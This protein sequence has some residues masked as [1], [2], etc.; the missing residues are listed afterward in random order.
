PAHRGG[1]ITYGYQ[2][3]RSE[4]AGEFLALSRLTDLGFKDLFRWGLMQSETWE[5]IG[6]VRVLERCVAADPLDRRSRLALS[7]IMRGLG[8]LNRAEEALAGLDLAGPEVIAA[9]VRI[10]LDRRDRSR[11]ERL[12]AS[13]L[14]GDPL[15]ARLRG[16]MALSRGDAR[17]ALRYYRVAYE[18]HPDVHEVLT[19]L[20]TALKILGDAE[21]LAPLRD[22][23]GKRNRL[24]LLIL[25]ASSGPGRDDP[26]LPPRL[27]DA[28]AALPRDAE[29]R[30]W[31]KLAIARN[32]LD[33]RAQRALFQLGT[34][35]RDGPPPDAPGRDR[36]KP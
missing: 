3:G 10:A 35:A 19:G 33:S 9:H 23:A 26:E 5:P 21:A 4:L 12:L 2:L 18:A 17:T 7:E 27:G 22:L 34:D 8:A 30:G 25:Q 28:C 24:R 32:P 14:P 36:P 11:A 15:L 13:G 20:M 1:T 16:R 6:V 31:Y 29:A